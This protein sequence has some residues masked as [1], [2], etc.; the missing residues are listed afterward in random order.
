MGDAAGYGVAIDVEKLAV[1]LKQADGGD[2][3]DES[4]V[5]GAGYGIGVD[6]GDFA[7]ETEFGVGDAALEKGTVDAAEADGAGAEFGEG[8]HKLLVDEAGEDGSDDVEAGG[9]GDAEAADEA[10]HS[11]VTLHPL[12][13]DLATA[14]DDDD[15]A[16]FLLEAHQVLEGGV[17][18]AEG[19]AADFND[20]GSF[21]HTV[22]VERGDVH[23]GLLGGVGAVEG[24]VLF[25]EVASPGG[26]AVFAEVEVDLDVHLSLGHEGDDGVS[27][28]GGREAVLHDERAVDVE[29]ELAFF[30]VGLAAT[31]GNG[32]ASPVG[33]I[34]VDGGLDEAGAGLMMR[35]ALRA[36]RR[37]FAPSTVTSMSLVAPSPS[38]AMRLARSMQTSARALEK[39]SAPSVPGRMGPAPA[40]PLAM[41]RTVSLVL[42]SPS[43]VIM[44]NESSAASLSMSFRRSGAISA[45]VVMKESMVA[46]SGWIMPAPLAMPPMVMVLPLRG[47][48]APISLG[49]GSV[50]R[51]ARA[52]R[53]PPSVASWMR[54]MPLSMRD[55][56]SSTPTMPV[57]Q[58]RT[59][60]GLM[61]RTS[62][63]LA[64]MRL[65]VAVAGIADAGIGDAA[66]YNNSVGLSVGH[67]LLGEDDGGGLELILGEYAGGGGG[68]SGVED[69]EVELVFSV[70][71]EAGKGGAG[72]V[73]LGRGDGAVFDQGDAAGHS[74]NLLSKLGFGV[75]LAEGPGFL[76][77]PAL[78]GKE[79]AGNELVA[80]VGAL[81]LLLCH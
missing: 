73:A 35:A 71:L 12:G 46:M 77:L 52:I 25:A 29:G 11:A 44:L 15:A 23:F 19:A 36:C 32:D 6:L 17:V 60:S 79:D 40:A 34:A 55:M 8:G 75:G 67:V 68:P 9:V 57:E 13:D 63:V 16:S 41:S 76:A 7:D 24:D 26:G 39:S 33:V 27:V 78:L 10:G 59:S 65:S 37:V 1:A 30:N 70:G 22:G 69:G 38:R 64:V 31:E 56:G 20:D 50:V 3:G 14:V 48:E 18:A 4:G 42:V 5:E 81:S 43:M 45:S 62:A 61:P 72:H 66:V 47:K 74:G 49:P 51:M 54:S 80:A 58:M 28:E 21:R 53:C 2:E